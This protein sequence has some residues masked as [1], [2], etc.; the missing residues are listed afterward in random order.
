MNRLVALGILLVALLALGV[1]TASATSVLELTYGETVAYVQDNLAGDQNSA[2]GAITFIGPVG[3]WNINVT[4]GLTKP[5]LGSSIILTLDL[6]SVNLNSSG[7]GTLT[8]KFSDVDFSSL[9][10]IPFNSLIGG[11]TTGLVTFQTFLGDGNNP[12]EKTTNLGSLVLSSGAFSGSTNSSALTPSSPF[13]LTEVL[14][15]THFGT[16]VTSLDA[17]VSPVPEPGT[18]LLLGSGL[19]GVGFWRLRKK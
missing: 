6:S 1:P 14:T 3:T 8:I 7:T 2:R 4:T 10:T 19:A 16:G 18:P 15:I 17:G 9:D 5:L 11:T 13:S 12:F